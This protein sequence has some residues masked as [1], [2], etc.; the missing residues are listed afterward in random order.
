M[1]SFDSIE[2]KSNTKNEECLK[3]YP[4]DNWGLDFYFQT[5]NKMFICDIVALCEYPMFPG[6]YSYLNHPI[7]KVDIIGIIV[8][9]DQN[10]KCFM[11]EVDDGTGVI[12]CSCWKVSYSN[13][14]FA[15]VSSDV[16]HLK[17]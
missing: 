16:H 8:K 9:V 3:F 5:Y 14:Y 13:Q 6:A 12:C 2:E 7:Y 15:S 11:Y 4:E 17:H 10:S 1:A